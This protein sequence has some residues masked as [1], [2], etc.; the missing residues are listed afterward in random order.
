MYRV[1]DVKVATRQPDGTLGEPRDLPTVPMFRIEFTEKSVDRRK[2]YTLPPLTLA[3]SF[4]VEKRTMD[5]L[6]G[7]DIRII[8]R[9]AEEFK[10][11]ACR[12]IYRRYF[13]KRYPENLN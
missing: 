10:I 2:T 3:L 6:T 11:N 12:E 5:C 1:D 7:R 9:M 8:F 13:M 4:K